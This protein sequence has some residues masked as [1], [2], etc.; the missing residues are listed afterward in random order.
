M[1]AIRGVDGRSEGHQ[2]PHKL[3][4]DLMSFYVIIFR[5]SSSTT[6]AIRPKAFQS[7]YRVMHCRFSFIEILCMAK[8]WNYS[9]KLNYHE[10]S[11]SSGVETG[12]QDAVKWMVKRNFNQKYFIGLF[13]CIIQTEILSCNDDLLRFTAPEDSNPINLFQFHDFYQ[14]SILKAQMFYL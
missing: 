11:D 12:T 9:N 7:Y 1:C 14:I 4:Y 6:I 3:Q 13:S 10:R 2:T 5:R 8:V